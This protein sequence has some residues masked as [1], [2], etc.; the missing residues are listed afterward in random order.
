MKSLRY[1][2][3]LFLFG[4]ATIKPCPECP[5][6]KPCPSCPPL[7][8]DTV[9]IAG[10]TIYLFKDT[11]LYA[12]R[13]V[14]Y[15][16]S[17][18]NYPQMKAALDYQLITPDA[19]VIL[20]PG[21]YTYTQPWIAA[22]IQDGK[23]KQCTPRIRGMFPAR[24]CPEKFRANLLPTFNDAFAFGVQ[25][26][27]SGYFNDIAI[28]GVYTFPNSL[29][30]LQ[31]DTL[32]DAQWNVGVRANS[33]TPH[34]GIAIDPF[35]D[36]VGFPIDWMYPSLRNFYIPSTGSSR[37]GST[38][39]QMNGIDVRNF[40]VGV[41]ITP[42]NQQNGEIIH[43]RNSSIA[44]CKVAYATCQ[45]QSKTNRIEDLEV[46]G[47]VRTI[48]DNMNYGVRHGDGAGSPTV[49][50]INIA[51]NIF[52]IF[53]VNNY[54]FQGSFHHIY[55]ELIG[56]LGSV[57]GNAGALV[58]DMEIA[59]SSGDPG[60][61]MPDYY[62]YASNTIFTNCMM[63]F[64]SESGKYKRFPLNG[65]NNEFAGG[66]VT[67]PPQI[68]IYG[69]APVSYPRIRGMV[70]YAL[71]GVFNDS[72]YDYFK[73]LTISN[74]HVNSNGTGWFTRG[75]PDP[76]Q[77]R[78]NFTTV[79]ANDLL[80]TEHLTKEGNMFNWNYPVGFVSKISGDTVY[81]DN[82]GVGIKNGELLVIND[83]GWK[84]N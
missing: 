79:V 13:I 78:G 46:W 5:T 22:I 69:G 38:A 82:V 29:T 20:A 63:R 19:E 68:A 83:F 84:L 25:V 57:G 50:G 43:L 8:I 59:F 62:V 9:R 6:I 26:A 75:G 49:D 58:E 16:L 3:I 30:P 77:E 28:K 1:L 31:I 7:K 55:G 10:P 65:A 23:Y 44:Y 53:R 80:I 42:S 61:F 54:A 45:A 41:I 71:N 11:T 74:V 40:L 72:H 33:V 48:I 73:W 81:L 56:R 60:R 24:N 76:S 66:Q 18:D 12:H 15:P 52:E 47:H 64:Y 34:C 17:G 32:T 70:M 36:S 2:I 27:K 14:L 67:G 4:C 35:S 39:F 51:D 21:Y 37:S